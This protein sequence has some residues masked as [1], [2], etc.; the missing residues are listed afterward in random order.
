MPALPAITVCTDDLNRLYAVLDNLREE[1][2]QSEYLHDELE[3]AKVVGN[4]A[5][6]DDV[7]SLGT[8]MRFRNL[9]TGK[10]HDRVLTLPHEMGQSDDAI[11]ILS[12]AGAAMLGLRI[13]DEIKWPHRNGFLRLQ[14]LSLSRDEA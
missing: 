6:P 14:L 10:D 9:E 3:R 1:S 11:S 5:L 4:E 8:R 13:G 7:V 2:D 12:P